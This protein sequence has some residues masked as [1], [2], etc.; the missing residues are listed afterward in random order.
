MT[1]CLRSEVRGE[2]TQGSIAAR[3]ASAIACDEARQRGSPVASTA[4]DRAAD[5]AADFS[6]PTIGCGRYGSDCN[7]RRDLRSGICGALMCHAPA[8][9]TRKLASLLGRSGQS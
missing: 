1:G 9:K 4:A 5:L 2:T 6:T 8:P 3:K 7:P